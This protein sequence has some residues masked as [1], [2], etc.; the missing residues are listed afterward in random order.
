MKWIFAFL[1]IAAFAAQPM[2]AQTL[3][4]QTQLADESTVEDEG[5]IKWLSWEEALALSQ[6][7]ERKVLLYIHTKWCNW[8]KRMDKNTFKRPEIADYINANYYPVQF[9]AEQQ[10]VLE[11]RGKTYQFVE[12]QK[13]G[14]HELAAELLKGRMSYPSIVFM[15]EKLE[16]IQPIIGFKYAEE[17]MKILSYFA[18]DHYMNTP[19]STFQRQ[20]EP[21]LIKENR[22]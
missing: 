3:E 7:E 20:Y 9:D 13:R 16:V 17:L 2:A 1:L 19:W 5:E 11:Y 10:K 15:D 21:Q 18:E 22:R 4:L 8:C 14:Y 6:K 12:N